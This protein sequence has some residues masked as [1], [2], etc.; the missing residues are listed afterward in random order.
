[1]QGKRERRRE[2]KRKEKQRERGRETEIEKEKMK[3]DPEQLANL[4]LIRSK[5]STG[6]HWSK[7]GLLIHVE[8]GRRCSAI[9]RVRRRRREMTAHEL[10]LLLLL[11][12]LSIF[13]HPGRCRQL[14]WMDQLHRGIRR[15]P[16]KNFFFSCFSII[17]FLKLK[18][19][20]RRLLTELNFE[21][22]EHLNCRLIYITL[23]KRT[24]KV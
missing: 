1:M 6:A 19:T 16:C 23:S 14:L 13:R 18:T 17:I 2:R 11:L 15:S 5:R 8:V 9:H 22:E 12:L 10:L 3:A 20:I 4:C 24:Q 21:D 7:E